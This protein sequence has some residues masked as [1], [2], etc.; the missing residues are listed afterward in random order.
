[1]AD[2]GVEAEKGPFEMGNDIAALMP[3]YPSHLIY[4]NP[5]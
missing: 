1:M 2:H 4:A 5:K 3:L